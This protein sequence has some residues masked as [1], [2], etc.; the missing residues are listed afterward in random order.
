MI[1]YNGNGGLN[2]GTGGG[3]FIIPDSTGPAD[4]SIEALVVGD[5]KV[6]LAPGRYTEPRSGRILLLVPRDGGGIPDTFEWRPL[7][8]DAGSAAI[9]LT[10]VKLLPGVERAYEVH[11]TADF[12]LPCGGT[13][14]AK[15]KPESVHLA[16]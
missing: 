1:V 10:S 13:L 15:C 4:L 2:D 8:S 14:D 9:D 16:Y 3:F 7:T 12:V 6:E 5:A 11:G